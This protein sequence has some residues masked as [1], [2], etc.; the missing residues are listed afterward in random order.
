MAR[1][2]AIPSKDI[3]MRI[4]GP[5]GVFNA[6]RVQRVNINND[7]PTTDIYELG[8]EN[9][10]GIA[11]DTPNLTVTFSA[12]DTGIK[13]I[14]VMTGNDWTAYPAGGVSVTDMGEVD[15]ILDIKDASTDTIVKAGHG[16]R[17]QVR[18]FS[19]SYS[20]DGEATEDYT[21]IGS[22]KRWFSNEVVVDVIETGTTSFTLTETPI[23]LKNGDYLLSVILDSE[24]L[25]ETTGTPESGEYS[26]SGTT[27]TTG[28]SMTSQFVAVYHASPGETWVNMTDSDMPAA[29]RGR[30][31][32]V[33]ISAGDI[34][35]VQSVTINGNMNAQPVREMGTRNVVGY[36]RQVPVIE[37]TITVLDTDTELISLFTTGT[38]SGSQEFTTDDLCPTGGL[39]LKI[40]LLDPCD[41]TPPYTV[42]KT[43]YLEGIAITGDAYTANVNN[44]ATQTFNFRSVSASLTV[45]SGAMP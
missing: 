12:F 27:V 19:Y 25:T 8:N 32:T 14:A 9:I 11:Q 30:D 17:L 35:R 6:S 41:S 28:D 33:N 16:K 21:L 45:Y 10:S 44:N 23:Q 42:F 38:I 29:I 1:R 39:P 3:Q 36:Q 5:T 4:V 13:I 40:E 26:V 31:I 2:L 18:D 37:G 15:I 7:I 20:V 22:E 43:L 34:S 24:Y